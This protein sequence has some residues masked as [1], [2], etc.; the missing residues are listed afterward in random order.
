M[1]VGEVTEVEKRDS[2][3]FQEELPPVAGRSRTV[4]GPD[5]VPVTGLLP[6]IQSGLAR[7]ALTV[8]ARGSCRDDDE[9]QGEREEKAQERR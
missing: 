1:E 6:R 4:V 7:G 9:Q 5:K 3:I 2:V 8:C